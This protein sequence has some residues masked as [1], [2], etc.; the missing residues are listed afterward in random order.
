V[1]A[2]TGK[3]RECGAPLDGGTG[4]ERVTSDYDAST[5]QVLEGLEAVRKRPA[6][7][8]GTTGVDGLHHLVWEV[9]DNAVDEA[10]AGICDTIEV[11][12]LEDGGLSVLDNG[13][14]IPIDVHAELGRP[15][16]EVVLTVLHAGGKFGEGGAYK[17]SGGLHGVGVSVVNAL[18]ELLQVEVHQ[19]GR[20]WT[21]EYRRGVVMGDL[22]DAGPTTHRGTRVTFWADPDIFTETTEFAFDTLAQRLREL[23]FLNRGLRITIVD[24]RTGKS[25]DFLYKGGIY[26]FVR[27]LNE[28][29]NVLHEKPVFLE[30]E[31]GGMTA[32]I[33]MQWNDGYSS[34]V[35]SFANSIHTTDGG[36]HETGFRTALTKALGN[37]ATRQGML[38]KAKVKLDGEDVREGLTCIISVKLPQ[39]QFEGQTKARLGTQEVRSFVEQLVYEK[40]SAY[41]DE[42]PRIAKAIIGKTI[43]AAHAREAA[44]KARE[45]TRR[46]SALDMAGLPG[47]LADCQERDPAKAELYLV[48]GDSAGGT[49]KQGRN[50]AYQAILPLRGKILNVQRARLDKVLG[51]QEI[52]LL[53]QALG[54]S[55]GSELDLAKLRY[56]RVVIMSVDGDEHVI[57]RDAKG[58]RLERIGR[59]VD[60]ALEGVPARFDGVTKRKGADLGDVLCF[61]LGSRDVR[62]RP[63]EAVIR[64][65]L[66]EELFEITTAY[67]RRVKVTASHSVFVAEGDEIALKRG[68]ELRVGDRVVAPR[69]VRLPVTAPARIDLV[70]ALHAVPEAARQVMLRGPAVEEL[71]RRRVLAEHAGDPSFVAPRVEIPIEVRAELRP[72]RLASGMTLREACAA[73]GI[74][75]PVTL[76][77]WEKG[78]SRPT[79]PQFQTYLRVIGADVEDVMSRARVGP[80]RL[81]RTW[82]EQYRG[83]PR[84][85]VR[86][87]ILL[88]D[89]SAAELELLEG[90]DDLT[91]T[92]VHHRRHA[93]GRFIDV[94]PELMTLLGFHL[95]EGSCSDRNGIR[96]CMGASN[97]RL[98]PEM[99]RCM[100]RV[101]GLKPRLHRVKARAAQIA[102]VNRVAALAWR[103]VFGFDGV[104]SITKSIP[105]I[106]LTVTQE[107]RL[108]FLRGYLLGDG[109]VHAGGL[110]FSTSS[111]DLAGGLSYL[112]GSLGVVPSISRVEPDGVARE[113]RGRA[114]ITRHPSWRMTVTSNEDLAVLRP[115]WEGHPRARALEARLHRARPGSPRHFESLGGDLMAL[116]IRRI[117]KVEASN[118]QVYDLSVADDEN[119]IA[120]IGGICCH[121]T[122]A[123]VDGS[124]I[125]TLLLTFFHNHFREVIERGYLYIAQPPLFR[126]K[127]GKDERYVKDEAELTRLI[128]QDAATSSTVSCGDPPRALEA[129]ELSE[130]VRKLEELL[131]ARE[132]LAK[133]FPEAVLDALVAASSEPLAGGH[134][135][136]SLP[137]A[138]AVVDALAKAGIESEISRIEAPVAAPPV[139]EATAEGESPQRVEVPAVEGFRVRAGLVDVNALLSTRRYVRVRVLENDLRASL[140][141]PFVI[142][143]ADQP[144][145]FT[146]RS[147]FLEDLKA[148]GQKGWSVQRYKGLGE[149][150]PEQLWETTLDPDRRSLLQVKLE[151]IEA[152][153]EIFDLLM[154]DEV[155]GRRRFIEQNALEVMNLDV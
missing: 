29:R 90:C 68:D 74:S 19:K 121:N 89:L 111:Q 20:K 48:E 149:M 52:L 154:G 40:L 123:D 148:R 81:E 62:F 115:A 99:G 57:V 7:Y 25:A 5:I 21:Q 30:G 137:Q 64:H 143:V 136:R 132:M 44:R 71:Y 13:R 42:N 11:T 79:L 108:S 83:A 6:M 129:R 140:P 126:V 43:D 78:I 103:H 60:A 45:A 138:Q 144:A 114:C 72:L 142:T 86:P 117:A 66:E 27:S 124:H 94:T 131:Q 17:V 9:V 122:D 69:R 14:G 106:A 130:I 139:P 147:K 92:P 127:K 50:R 145:T 135:F 56:H 16:V 28:G 70:R 18:S 3:C 93:L 80:N 46:K 112:L 35:L 12:I 75:Q 34:H 84:N 39:P 33:A 88:A 96:L 134:P 155:E 116:P 22:K 120:G 100:E 1:P 67:G 104:E 31:Q 76:Y 85:K 98:I 107:L 128:V 2:L 47:K 36:T 65:P 37:Y 10:Q 109:S 146:D 110:G 151:D 59:L 141:P 102:L 63:I 105:A 73:V 119:F 26:E 24:R 49:A 41:L 77:A 152:A 53:V 61:G 4:V 150:N 125:R 51:N 101:F 95:A 8:I 118:G 87:Y 23:A 32:E 58:A 38:E 15:A 82:Q 113:I 54:A 133:R 55:I 97:E 91:L 153:E